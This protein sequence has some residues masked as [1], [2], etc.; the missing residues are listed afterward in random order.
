[1]YQQLSILAIL[2][3]QAHIFKATTVKFDARYSSLMK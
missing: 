1:L 3:L 2:V